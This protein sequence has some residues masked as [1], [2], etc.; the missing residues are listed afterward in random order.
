MLISCF[1]VCYQ[2]TGTVGT[3]MSGH[4]CNDFTQLLLRNNDIIQSTQSLTRQTRPS[5]NSNCRPGYYKFT[6]RCLKALEAS[7]SMDG[8]TWAGKGLNNKVLK[9]EMVCFYT[10]HPLSQLSR[11]VSDCGFTDKSKLVLS[12][13]VAT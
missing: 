12:L 2:W 4:G 11:S 9:I 10:E 1:H 7:L 3:Q 8:K 13:S 5:V 6:G